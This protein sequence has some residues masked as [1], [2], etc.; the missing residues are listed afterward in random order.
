M[1]GSTTIWDSIKL[2]MAHVSNSGLSSGHALPAKTAAALNKRLTELTDTVNENMAINSRR[3]TRLEGTGG[4]STGKGKSSVAEVDNIR[5]ALLELNKEVNGM[6]AEDRPEVVRFAGITLEDQDDA[7]AWIETNLAPDLV[8]YIMDPHTVLEHL[9]TIVKGN[10]DS[11]KSFG[12]AKKLNFAN[13]AQAHAMLSYEGPMP[14]IMGSQAMLVVLDDESHL[15]LIP[16]WDTWDHA[17]T[18]LREQFKTALRMFER[19]A[20]R[21]IRTEL[22]SGTSGSN[23]ARLSLKESISFIEALFNFMDDFHKHLT[24][25]KFNDKK[26]HHV[27]TRLLRCILEEVFVPRQGVLTAFKPGDPKQIASSMLWSQLGSLQA[28]IELKDQGL[29]NLDIVAAKLVQFLLVNTQYDSIATLEADQKSMKADIK[30]ALA[31]KNRL[32]T[33]LSTANSVCSWKDCGWT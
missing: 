11:L 7:A 13:L 4:S 29:E 22:G 24:T 16:T 20:L 25:G 30:E 2:V 12:R 21:T 10:L 1:A 18:G 23:L 33:S 31:N 6:K 9:C 8:G 3:L 27:S 14:K 15:D 19:G 5:A 28:A 17:K 26:A 32:E